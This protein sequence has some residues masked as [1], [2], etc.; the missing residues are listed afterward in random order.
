MNEETKN[1]LNIAKKIA[2]KQLITYE[3]LQG[4]V[5][6]VAN[7]LAQYRSA[8]SQINKETKDTLNTLVKAIESA[9]SEIIKNTEEEI[10]NKGEKIVESN[11][12]EI[13]AFSTKEVMRITDEQKKELAKVAQ[14]CLKM[15]EEMT[16]YRPKDGKDGLD[17]KDG[18]QGPQGP[19]GKDGKD[20]SN[21]T[22][23][24][25]VEKVNKSKTKIKHTQVDGLKESFDKLSSQ[26]TQGSIQSP[27]LDVYNAGSLLKTRVSKLNFSS[28]ATL[29]GDTVNISSGGGSSITVTEIDGSPSVSNPTAI[30][31]SNGSVTDNGDGTVTVTTG[32][33]GGGDFS[34]NTTVSV[35]GEVVL[36]SGTGGKTGKRAT[37]TGIA[38]LTS[39]VLSTATSG[40]DY[41]APGSITTDGITMNTAKVLGRA[42]AGIGAVEELSVTGS[43]SAVLATSPTLTTP[44]IGVATATS[45]NGVTVTN[46]GSG[47]LTVTGTT[48]VSGTNTGDQTISISGD[49]T[50]SGS[51]GVLSATVTKINGTSLAGLSTGILKNTTTTG[52]PSIAVAG[53]DYQVP[54]TAGDVTTSGATSTIGANKV[55]NAMLST[56]ATSTFKGRTTAGTGNVEDLTSTQATALLNNFVGDSGSGG[57]KGLVPSPATGD[58]TKF[59]KGDGTWATPSGGSGLAD[60]DYGDITVSGSGTVM[61]IDAST[62]GLTE[63]SATGTPSSSTF[64]RGDNTWATPAGSGT[65]TASGGSLTANSVVLGAG[66]T[67]TKVST[68]ITTDGTAQLNL[69]VNATTIG[70]VKLFGNTSGDATIQPSAVAGTGTVITLPATTGTVITTGDSDTVTPTMMSNNAKTSQIT[71]I[72]DGG[73]SAVASGSTVYIPCTFA[74]SII[75]YT[76]MVDTGTCTVKTWKVATGTAIPTVANSISTSGVA[77]ST[78]TAIRSTTL[79]DFTTTTITANDMLAF[80]ITA[81]SGATKIIFTLEV[82]KS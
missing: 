3:E 28:G 40:T 30:K 65:V 70:K 78:G 63:L 46:G 74:A 48:T 16:S 23:E 52:V 59:L 43:G 72:F 11:K 66:L 73:G 22:P 5:T 4:F 17:G 29:S 36:F 39:G 25:V 49:V 27:I 37:S 62:I 53:T 68:G 45:V 55:T 15:C 12:K 9:H 32:A 71:A 34:S 79:S 19:A 44:N 64:L 57:T 60:G 18:S 7:I 10:K 77:I 6:D 24:E 1:L 80:N 61:N 38:K 75:A 82:R 51:T 26:V 67:D 21:D 58:A 2:G 41:V 56:V 76:I 31:F 13:T 69:G 50:A 20:G 8:T 81:V 33:G 14:E 42:T 47:A 35:D 54:I